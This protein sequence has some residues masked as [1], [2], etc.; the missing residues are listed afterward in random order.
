VTH[1]ATLDQGAQLLD[2]GD[3]RGTSLATSA[4]RPEIDGLRAIAV[5]SVVIYHAELSL[6]GYSFLPGGFLGVDVFF[7][8]S[9]YLIGRIVIGDVSAGRFSFRDF[10]E[11]RVRRIAPALLLVIGATIPFAWSLLTIEQF[12]SFGLSIIS[13]LTFVSNFQFWLEDGYASEA[14]S[15]KP[16]LHTWSLAIEEQFYLF[17]PAAVLLAFALGRRVLTAA[18]LIALGLSILV[19]EYLTYR[20]PSASFYL[21][22]SRLWELLA[23][24]VLA[25]LEIRGVRRVGGL[26][27]RLLMIAALAVL[28]AY[29]CFPLI[30]LDRHPGFETVPVVIAV[31]AMI[32]A[33]G[34]GGRAYGLLSARPVVGLGLISYSFYLWHQPVFALAR[35]ANV[36]ELSSFLK[37]LLVFLS[38]A[39]AWASWKFVETPF[40]S[41]AKVPSR[42]LWSASGCGLGLMIV[43]GAYFAKDGLPM[44]YP[45][46]VRYQPVQEWKIL[47]QGGQP[48]HTELASFSCQFDLSGAGRPWMLVGD[49]HASVLGPALLD[50]LKQKAS[51]L[52]TWTW[53]GCPVIFDVDYAVYNYEGEQ[54]AARNIEVRKA[55]EAAPPSVVVYAA[56]MPLWLSAERFN[57]E[58]GGVEAGTALKLAV[59]NSD[60]ATVP[61]AVTET[62]QSIIE[63]GHELIVVYPVPE[64]GWSVP[65]ALNRLTP[66]TPKLAEE[67]LARQGVTTSLEVFRRRSAVAYDAYDA[68]GALP[69]VHR[70][71]PEHVFCSEVSM[72][73]KTHD[74]RSVWYS[75]DDHLSRAGA[76]KVVSQIFRVISNSL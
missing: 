52:T 69:N 62:L 6:F 9:G 45:E 71:Y 66:K 56:R 5:I 41:K 54:C 59:K 60:G 31:M 48:C 8:I 37:I 29:V 16:L 49:S 17:F 55:L 51:R 76:D 30:T 74:V 22:P 40:R 47:K 20:A 42:V 26:S 4:Y 58:E 68:I 70:V 21:L 15:L 13:S 63:M 27:A 65:R 10:Y 12:R 2:D 61:Q 39:L 43:C 38:G 75:D 64:V 32:W 18:L 3:S 33:D 28:V 46:S 24:T 44:R 50:G 35:N 34:K 36:D 67:W 72:R 53:G 19:A 57:N 14:S 23:G 1:T 11:R 73:C 7:V 25:W